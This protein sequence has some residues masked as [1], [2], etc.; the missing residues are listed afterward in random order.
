MKFKLII[1]FIIFNI[2]SLFSHKFDVIGNTLV[3]VDEEENNKIIDNNIVPFT[4]GIFSA[5]WDKEYIFFDFKITEPLKFVYNQLD[6]KPFLMET[7]NSGAD[8]LFLIK[9][10]YETSSKGSKII[11]KLDEIYFHIYS[12]VEMKSLKVGRKK[13]NINTTLNREE[14]SKYLK[15]LGYNIL[16]DIYD[17]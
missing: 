3:I 12:L 13:I 5:L 6:I 14:K 8:T 2:F 10:N 11:L 1:F 9:V 4:E 15:E 17:N 7:R 16:F